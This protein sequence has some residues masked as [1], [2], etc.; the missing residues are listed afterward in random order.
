MRFASMCRVVNTFE[1]SDVHVLLVARLL[2]KACD[3]LENV[4]D[5]L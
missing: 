5:R 2:E 3:K 4:G 1:R